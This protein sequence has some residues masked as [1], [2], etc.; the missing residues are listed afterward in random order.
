MS[1]AVTN[2]DIDTGQL[3]RDFMKM[4]AQQMLLEDINKYGFI[5]GKLK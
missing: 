5:K 2:K 3:Y 1:S 4:I